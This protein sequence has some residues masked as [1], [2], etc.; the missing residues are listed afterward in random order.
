MLNQIEQE[1]FFVT[2]LRNEFQ[3]R[4][5]RSKKY[6][7]RAYARDLSLSP[8]TLSRILRNERPLP[9]KLITPIMEALGL[10]NGIRRRFLESCH[11]TS[12]QKGSRLNTT[13]RLSVEETDFFSSWE[14][15]C[16]LRLFDAPDF[17]FD[18]AHVAQSLGVT[19]KKAAQIIDSLLSRGF[20]TLV[21]DRYQ[22][23]YN[24]LVMDDEA[25]QAHAR[26]LAK[27]LRQKPLRDAI[28]GTIDQTMTTFYATFEDM[29]KLKKLLRQVESKARDRS[30]GKSGGE[31]YELFIQVHQ[32][33]RRK[34]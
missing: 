21:N 10:K 15:L 31:V 18:T 7:L 3:R 19:K 28:K 22:R 9:K 32:R 24:H 16:V 33:T 20:V 8:S 6:S 13:H 27:R 29:E 25:M 34:T 2:F 12:S 5:N 23:T 26:Y 4:M 17:S 14:Y 11:S 30:V 1:P